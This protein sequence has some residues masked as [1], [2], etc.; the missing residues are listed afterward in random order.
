MALT[1][2]TK[3]I[4]D[5]HLPEKV[6]DKLAPHLI[7]AEKRMRELIGNDKYDELEGLGDGEEYNQASL[8]ESYL[9][10]F[11]AFPT[12]GL[13]PTDRGG[14]VRATGMDQS[15]NELMSKRELDGYRS[16]LYKQAMSLLA[17]MIEIYAGDEP[18][19]TQA[20]GLGFEAI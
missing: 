2:E 16:Q 3:I 10:G 11:F 1:N 17:D 20:G 5:L 6:Y 8:A 9:T 19:W 4:S 15:R 12:L 18:E 13:R 7:E 14:F